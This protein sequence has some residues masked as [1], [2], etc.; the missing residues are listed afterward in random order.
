VQTDTS[1]FSSEGSDSSGFFGSLLENIQSGVRRGGNSLVFSGRLTRSQ[2][3]GALSGVGGRN[4]IGYNFVNS[5]G[6]TITNIANEG[7]GEKPQIKV[8]GGRHLTFINFGLGTPVDAGSG[9]GNGIELVDT[10]DSVFISRWAR[11]GLPSF[12]SLSVKAVTLDANSDRNRF[13][14]L[15]LNDTLANEITDSGSDN[16]FESYNYA[17]SVWQFSGTLLQGEI[18]PDNI[19]TPATFDNNADSNSF[20][21]IDGG[22]TAAQVRRLE[23][24]DRGTLKWHIQISTA[25][26]FTLQ[27]EGVAPRLSFGPTGGTTFRLGS[28][29]DNY[30][31]Q[32][33]AGTTRIFIEGDADMIRFGSAIDTNLYRSAADTL[34]TD[35]AFVY[36]NIVTLD[37]TGTPSVAGANVFTTGGTTTITAFDDGVNGQIITVIAAHSLQITDGASL[38]LNGGNYG[39]TDNDTLALVFDGSEWYETG[40]AVD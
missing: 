24:K 40:R 21:T 23:F 20:V 15:G 8:D 16:Y 39:M 38:H 9:V 4:G 25:D 7:R 12:T 29:T 17:A 36:R 10:T 30:L 37:D 19:L 28:L 1:D 11:A 33:S 27:E 22:A 26:V 14:R 32:D 35:D 3:K 18:D 13:F 34:K 5:T 2:F 31:F 6:S